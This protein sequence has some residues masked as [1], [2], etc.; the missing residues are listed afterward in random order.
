MI[1][2][3]TPAGSST[4]PSGRHWTWYPRPCL[5]RFEL[6]PYVP[7]QVR[8][9]PAGDPAHGWMGSHCGNC[10]SHRSNTPEAVGGPTQHHRSSRKKNSPPSASCSLRLQPATRALRTGPHCRRR[11][12]RAC[13]GIR[14]RNASTASRQDA[15]RAVPALTANRD[16]PYTSRKAPRGTVDRRL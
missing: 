16:G 7:R 14:V 10:A 6:P 3:P 9:P 4:S 2:G 15:C 1:G 8:T 11:L 5:I 13:R 12:L